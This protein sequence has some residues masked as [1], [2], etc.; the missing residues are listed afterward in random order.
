[1]VW[2]GRGAALSFFLLR[3]LC[4]CVEERDGTVAS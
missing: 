2:F 4:G 3:P 1:L